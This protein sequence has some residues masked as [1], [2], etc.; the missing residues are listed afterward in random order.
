MW[1]RQNLQREMTRKMLEELKYITNAT[2]KQC[3]GCA[4]FVEDDPLNRNGAGHCSAHDEAVVGTSSCQSFKL[5][6]T[7]KPQHTDDPIKEEN[8][9]EQPEPTTDADPVS[10][11]PE[12]GT[13]CGCN[14]NDK[15]V[16]SAPVPKHNHT[17]KGIEPHS[18]QPQSAEKEA[19]KA[20]MV[21][22]ASVIIHYKDKE[23]HATFRFNTKRGYPQTQIMKNEIQPLRTKLNELKAKFKDDFNQEFDDYIKTN[24]HVSDAFGA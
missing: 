14:N 16:Q 3:A 13:G 9:G 12:S 15:P 4:F 23:R 5:F 18:T 21:L 2:E 19:E 8:K 20:K 17:T 1:K 7:I 6:E 10:E 11:T 22:A 24:R